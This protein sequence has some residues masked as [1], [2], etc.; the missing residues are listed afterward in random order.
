MIFIKKTGFSEVNHELKHAYNIQMEKT[1][2]GYR[3]IGYNDNKIINKTIK[4]KNK[5]RATTKKRKVIRK[6]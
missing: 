1:K 6:K 4:L 3:I 5:K 2:N